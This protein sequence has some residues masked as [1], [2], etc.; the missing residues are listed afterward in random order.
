MECKICCSSF[1]DQKRKGITCLYCQEN[2]CTECVKKYLLQNLSDPDC[3]MCKKIW[4]Q[5]FLIKNL[6]KG[7]LNKE[8][9]KH[10][11]EVLLDRERSL[12][13]DTMP[14]AEIEKKIDTFILENRELRK[15]KKTI[16]VHINKYFFQN[17]NGLS[18]DEYIEL[19]Q[20]NADLKK[21]FFSCKIQIKYNETKIHA[22]KTRDFNIIQKKEFI[23][24]CPVTNCRGFLSTQWKCG[25]CNTFSCSQCHE[26]IG[27]NKDDHHTCTPESIK[28]VDFIKSN[29]K[30]CPNCGTYIYK[31]EGCDQMFCT[32]CN[33]AFS[34]RNLMIIHGPI[35]NPHY[36]EFLKNNQININPRNNPC[37]TM[38]EINFEEF[39]KSRNLH[40]KKNV[41]LLCR[42][43]FVLFRS[44][45]LKQ[46]IK[47]KISL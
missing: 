43:T 3:M 12:F 31:I 35:H 33:M 28:S 19:Q 45:H 24:E 34:W 10:R 11:E 25:L 47:N 41:Y 7:F 2:I 9:K 30:Q 21:E 29:S 26:I 39:L 6:S 32:N 5:D 38:E 44:K 36:F 16:S 4:N 20:K 27:L 42:G 37:D 15:K 40:I 23:K 46:I 22:L 17:T 18:I 13:H 14:Y 1:T 8:Y